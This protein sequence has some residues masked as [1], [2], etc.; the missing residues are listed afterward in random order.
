VSAARAR[1]LVREVQRHDPNWRP[2]PSLYEGVEGEIL[3]NES[4]AVQA[5]ARLRELSRAEPVRGPMEEILMPNGQHVGMR[6]RN[7]DGRTRTVTLSEFNN[8]LEALAPGS[9]IVQSPVGYRGFWY[10]RP[11]GS[12]FGVRRSEAHG[13][14]IDVIRYDHLDIPNGYKVHQQ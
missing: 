12:I 7:T 2:T 5:T 4:A 6:Y 11:D 1:A 3:A 14:T 13:I 9:Q 8:L 10:R